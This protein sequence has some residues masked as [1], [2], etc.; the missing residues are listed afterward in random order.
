[1][2][3]KCYG[4]GAILQTNNKEEKG[5][6]RE[7]KYN[8]SN[9][10]ERCF[11]I[12]HYNEKKVT[13]L[14]NINE[15]I[16]DEVNKKASFVYFLIDFLNINTETINTYKKIKTNKILIISKID[17][18]P[19]SIKNQTITNWLKENYGIKEDIIYQSSKKNINVKSLM[20]H[21]EQEKIKECY[22]LGYT[23]A[24]KSTLINKLRSINNVKDYEL[25]TSLLPNTTIDFIK[26]RINENLS[27]I[28]S[29]GFTL[30]N[31]FYEEDNFNLIKKSLPNT[32]LKPTTYQVK[33][34]SSIIIEDKVRIS[35]SN[36]NSF[37]FYMSNNID[38]KRVFD[39][40]N[41]LKNL[42]KITIDIKENSDLIIKSLGFINIKK[43]C[44]LTIYTSNK[45]L[46]EVRNSMFQ[47]NL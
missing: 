7:D 12:T 28:D 32:L 42:E 4:C 25:T 27:I 23:N 21:L 39:N 33:E 22:I 31:T 3:K 43:P 47:N 36:K 5:Y 16:I 15:Y 26:I 37:T 10:C 2:N 34:I 14:E 18:I 19:K 35:S 38:I 41:N 9:Y 17:I 13:H 46:F 24:G 11:K 44:K 45:S 40:N 30:T 20:S 29:P 1:M 6:I 8:N